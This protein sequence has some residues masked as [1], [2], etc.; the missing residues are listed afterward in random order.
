[1][2][3]AIEEKNTFERIEV[4]RKKHILEPETA[5]N[6]NEALKLFFKIRLHQQVSKQETLN[7][8]D[9]PQLERTERDLLRHS[10]HV[11]KKF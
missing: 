5:D 3:Y 4:L 7:N 1:L 9:I 11:V 6:F 8:I 2:E 10:V